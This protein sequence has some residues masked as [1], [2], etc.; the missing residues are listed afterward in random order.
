MHTAASG[1][2][3]CTLLCHYS[4]NVGLVLISIRSMSRLQEDC[5]DSGRQS[6]CC[7]L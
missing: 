7:S 5:D 6:F 1:S 3:K 4:D 2:T